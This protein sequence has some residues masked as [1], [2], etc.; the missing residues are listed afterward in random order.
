[1][2]LAL[3]I[4]W[5]ATLAAL[6][7]TPASADPIS[8]AISLLLT[9]SLGTLTIAG[10]FFSTFL[11][12]LALTFG[13]S[14]LSRAL[15]PSQTRSNPG[16]QTTVTQTG[17]TN[18][19]SFII[20]KYA[21]AGTFVAPP[22]THG[23]NKYLTYII[24]FSAISGAQLSRIS[25]DGEWIT[26]AGTADPDYGTPFVGK[27]AGHGWVKWYDGTQTSA[28]QMLIAKYGGH[29][30]Y[31]WTAAHVG[32]GV[33]YGIFTFVADQ[34]IYSGLPSILAE[35]SG[36]A[37]Y[38]PRSDSTVGGSGTQRWSD[39][40]TWSHTD[41]PVVMIYNILRGLDIGGETYGG[42][43]AAEDLPFA[44]W[45]AAMNVCDQ[46]ITL[47]A[48]GTEPQYRAGYEVKIDAD[49]ASVIGELL[50]TCSGAISEIG[51]VWK[52]RAGA[53]SLPVFSF[54]DDDILISQ[55]Q[56][57]TPFQGQD[58]TFNGVAAT[59]PDVTGD[60]STTDAPRQHDLAA[61]AEDGRRSMGSVA[62][63]AAPYP[64]QVQRLMRAWLKDARR[65]AQH[66]ISL[67]PAALIVEPLDTVSWTSTVNGYVDKQ[68]EVTSEV[69]AGIA[70]RQ[71]LVLRETDPTDY[72]WQ[73]SYELPV[74]NVTLVNQSLDLV[75]PGLAVSSVLRIV[76]QQPAGV[77]Q[78]DVT[79]GDQVAA[80]YD[81]EYRVIGDASWTAL[82]H[83]L[84]GRYELAGLGDGTLDIRARGVSVSGHTSAWTTR[85]N[86]N[87]A[88]FAAA[89]AD[90]TGF[91]SVVIG[92]LAY[93][94]WDASPALDLSHYVL[95][96]SPRTSGV[97][98]S[99]ATDLVPRIA[100]P[101]TS[102]QIPVAVGTYLIKAVDKSGNESANAT[103]IVTT[104][105]AVTGMNIVETVDEAPGWTGT[106]A[107]IVVH[108]GGIIISD[109]SVPTSA[110]YD[111]AGS[112][113]LG[114]VFTSRFTLGL[115]FSRYSAALPTWDTYPGTIDTWPLIDTIG[116]DFNIADVSVRIEISTSQDMVTWSPW[117]GLI[118]GDYTARGAKFRAVLT[119]STAGASPWV[120][121]LSVRVDMPDRTVAGADVVSGA[122]A[123]MITWSPPFKASPAVG[124]TAQDMAPGDRFALTAKSAAGFTIEF[125]DQSGSPVSRTFDY[126]AKGYGQQ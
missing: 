98:W 91:D 8:T 74:S 77:L 43:V 78:V 117:S 31:P 107:N 41:N 89:P 92:G 97:D 58:K 122:G 106:G 126:Q 99:A 6:I 26:P 2:I 124:I 72:D 102:V 112:V 94:K 103:S 104:I 57:M 12:R 95:R 67:P 9:T 109:T 21:T 125:F 59:Y 108:S 44:E 17:G 42:L 18:P 55:S 115:I 64:V 85:S 16:L 90:V 54:T 84:A 49:A 19:R 36:A 5:L 38:D 53:P 29:P 48:G 114:A 33:V 116:L 62:L 22:L 51:G 69:S 71:S 75:P 45:T 123:K 15:A 20:G 70:M 76:R 119:T 11:G 7:A 68:F 96:F 79:A 66:N 37:L 13:L 86:Y 113:D 50:K 3:K 46:P 34:R 73:P 52:I 63:P 39:Q 100:R 81:V 30:D 14:A 93:L 61:E 10:G 1:M 25:I 80:S 88:P 120:T 4:L 101:A 32:F 60:W 105:A 121:G 35:I 83:G 23:N 65:F 40:T 118:V 28:D 27:Y 111:F 56:K 24:A 110:T 47:A 82:G 87:F